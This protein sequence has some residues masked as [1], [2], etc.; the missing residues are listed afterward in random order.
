MTILGSDSSIRITSDSFREGFS[1]RLTLGGKEVIIPKFDGITPYEKE[2]REF[3][4]A[5][6]EDREPLITAE[7]GRNGVR[8]MDAIKKTVRTKKVQKIIYDL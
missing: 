7:D 3:V 4:Q 2:I 5:I 8:V 6:I 1:S